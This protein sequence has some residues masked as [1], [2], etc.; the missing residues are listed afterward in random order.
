MW[1]FVMSYW[2]GIFSSLWTWW[3]RARSQSLWI[4]WANNPHCRVLLAT[5]HSAPN[6]PH[7]SYLSPSAF[8]KFNV[9][10]KATPFWLV[11]HAAVPGAMWMA[12]IACLVLTLALTF[13]WLWLR[14]FSSLWPSVFSPFTCLM[15]MLPLILSQSSDE[16]MYGEKISKAFNILQV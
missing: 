10:P 5:S 9:S 8:F 4:L 7:P 13:V 14:L 15:E 16:I 11:S 3:V 12:Q 6:N 1:L 2:E